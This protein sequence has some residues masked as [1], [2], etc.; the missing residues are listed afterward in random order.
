LRSSA[1]VAAALERGQPVVAL[2]S[3]LVVHGLPS[4]DNLGTAAAL[5]DAVR[6]HGAVPATVGVMFGEAVIGLT[7][8]E[9]AELSRSGAPKLGVRDLAPAVGSGA[10]GATTVSSTATLARQAGIA[11]FA[12]GGIGGVHRGAVRSWDVSADLDTLGRTPIVVVCSGVKSILDVGA[13]LERLETIGVTVVGYRTD[14]FPGFY[15]TDSGHG[16]E[17]T[18]NTPAEAAAVARA[19]DALGS[20]A[21]VLL[22]NPPPRQLDPEV[23]AEVL[24]DGLERAAA[25]GLGGKDVTP[26]LL[27]HFHEQTGG[28]S[29]AVNVELAVANAGVAAEV[30]VALSDG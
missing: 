28:D 5:E 27:G 16:V 3:T 10:S 12:T 23:H 8:A 26:F 1:E 15:L 17:W 6:A 25:E 24:A 2:E 14:R 30:A 13:T 7:S 4:P 29:L 21:A 11:V 19:R 22:A 9:L 20:P 18:V